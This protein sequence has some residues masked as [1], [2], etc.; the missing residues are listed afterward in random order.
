MHSLKVLHT[1]LTYAWTELP[2]CIPN[3]VVG[4]RRLLGDPPAESPGRIRRC[5]T[6]VT[7]IVIYGN[8]CHRLSR[9]P[10]TR[11]ALRSRATADLSHERT[12]AA[13]SLIVDVNEA[14]V[15]GVDGCE[16]VRGALDHALPRLGHGH[17]RA[18][19]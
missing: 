16:D 4:T 9:D 7:I 10:V 6:S 11:A 18:G 1:Y 8:Q 12:K 13:Y 3:E 5:N 14:H 15:H 19:R 17:R 2:W